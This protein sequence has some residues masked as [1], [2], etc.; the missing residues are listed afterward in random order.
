MQ[1]TIFSRSTCAPCKT[2]KYLL[3]KRG[4]SF[5]ERD[6]DDPENLA[7]FARYG[8]ASVPVIIIGDRVIHGA[9]FGAINSALSA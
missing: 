7:D 8:V 5:S 9:N 6:V 2:V 4:V 3:N 1:V